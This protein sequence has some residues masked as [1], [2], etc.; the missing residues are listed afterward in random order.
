MSSVAAYID[1]LL[2]G[3]P[4]DLYVDGVWRP[5]SSGDRFVVSDPATGQPICEVADGGTADGSAALD[6]ADRAQEAWA[7]VP[8]RE[9]SDLLMAAFH[10]LHENADAFAR[11]IT[12]EMGKSLAEARGEVTYG[13]EFLR[14]FAEEA[15]RVDGR[16]GVLPSG[17]L[18]M[19]VD[20][21]PVGPCLLITP[22]NFPLAMATRKI[23]PAL[24]AGC[25]AVVKPAELTPLTTLALT[26][27]LEEAGVPAGVVNVV[28]TADPAA[29]TGHLLAD[30][31][32][33]KLSFTG[34]TPVGKRLLAA[35]AEGV[36]RCSMELG[37]SAPF[38]VFE[39]ADLD[40][41]VAGA[42]AAKTRNIGEACTAANR[43]LVH[44]SVQEPFVERFAA[45]MG[46]LVVGSGTAHDTDLGPLIDERSRER[47]HALVTDAVAQGARAVVGGNLP[48]GPGHFYPATVLDGVAPDARVVTEEIFGPVAPVQT[49][50]D[51]DEAVRLANSTPYGLVG[52]VYT[53]DLDRTLRFVPRLQLGMVGVNTGVV[54]D[55]AAPFGGVKE[56]GLGREGG[57]EGIAEYL[58]HQYVGIVR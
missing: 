24:A 54:S 39:D 28:T 27:V 34:S 53:R 50:A 31:R 37:G 44:E 55:P 6:A 4:G 38:I 20:Q 51:E 12:A 52:Y 41:A 30:P 33:R 13:A 57:R 7:A 1:A 26:K 47:V 23:G 58:E 2:A 32:L 56:S 5:A 15:V 21:R 35:A 11:L 49:F 22:W 40:E 10:L 42:I 16:S 48:D 36:L 43:F 25:T 45:A 3:A 46:E 29:A 17:R 19:L 8:A 9:R 14:W 18:R